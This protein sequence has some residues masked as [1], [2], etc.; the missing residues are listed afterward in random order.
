MKSNLKFRSTISVMCMILLLLFLTTC[1]GGK[2]DG[3]GEEAS[4]VYIGLT[5]PAKINENNAK[6]LVIGAYEGYDIGSEIG[7]KDIQTKESGYIGRSLGLQMSQVL[8]D[9]LHGMDL[10]SKKAKTSMGVRSTE[11]DT[12]YGECGGSLSY[13]INV[14]DETGD[15]SG[16][17]TYNSYCSNG[18]IID[19]SANISGKIDTY[20]DE[21]QSLNFSFNNLT[22]SSDSYSF[23][24]AGTINY[25][26]IS[27]SSISASMNCKLRDNS[28]EK[29]YWVKDYAINFT[30]SIDYVEFEISGYY[31]DPDYGYVILSTPVPFVIY[32][33]EY[34]P[35]DGI[36]V[37]TGDT[38][39]AGGITKARLVALNSM[40]YQ[41][42]ADT[43]GDGTYNWNSGVLYWSEVSVNEIKTFGQ[44]IQ[45]S[46][47]SGGTISMQQR[48]HSTV[49]TGMILIQGLILIL[50]I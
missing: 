38:G 18:I 14:N 3:E 26:D 17:F 30:V 9:S 37:V 45:G 23:T 29:V 22:F 4:I 47:S 32:V 33:G 49:Y 28:T 39:I 50:L 5:T 35:S 8:E 21:F 12:I 48:E 1:G 16:D 25:H 41:I 34:G 40:T 6:D 36:L 27:S 42:E 2:N 46:I 19:G 15:F 13:T 24:I 20:T 7:V 11:S 31:Y 44:W 10:I 43:N